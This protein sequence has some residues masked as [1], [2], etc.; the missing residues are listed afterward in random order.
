MESYHVGKKQKSHRKRTITLGV[1]V[2]ILLL[3]G[4]AG[5]AKLYMRANTV[6]DPPPA[7][8]ISQVTTSQGPTKQFDEGPFTISL[9]A[10]WVYIG[11]QRQI[12]PYAPYAWHNTKNN[13]GV[14]QLEIYVDTIPTNLGVNRV[15]PVQGNGAHIVPTTVSDMCTDFTGDNKLPGAQNTPSKWGGINFLCDLANYERD[16]VGTS[17]SDGVNV[18]KISG[19]TT[20]AHQIFMTYTDS[21]ATPNFQIFVNAVGSFTLK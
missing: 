16:V 4:A 21:G 2:L 10:D 8:V 12:S 5:W 7:P 9:P 14:E 13:P 17:S 18:V 15:L 20:G 3:A 6:I 11:Q 1:V 19:A